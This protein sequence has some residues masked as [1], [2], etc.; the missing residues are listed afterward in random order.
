MSTSKMLVRFPDGVVKYG[1]YQNTSDV[2]SP[3]LVDNP[4]DRNNIEELPSRGELV[5]VDIYIPYGNGTYGKF[6]ARGGHLTDYVSYI[7]QPIG[8][9]KDRPPNMLGIQDGKPDWAKQ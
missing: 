9:G 2:G 1:C 7:H 5:I 4:E 6:T 8:F 3:F